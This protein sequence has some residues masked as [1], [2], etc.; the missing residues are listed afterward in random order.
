MCEAKVLQIEQILDMGGDIQDG[1]AEWV[2]STTLA[3]IENN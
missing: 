1:S 2:I 3:G